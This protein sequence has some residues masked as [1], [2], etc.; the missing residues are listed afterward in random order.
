MSWYEI[1]GNADRETSGGIVPSESGTKGVTGETRGAW[2]FKMV[3]VEDWQ[4]QA[5]MGLAGGPTGLH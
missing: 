1:K 5:T 3:N 4:V 2:S